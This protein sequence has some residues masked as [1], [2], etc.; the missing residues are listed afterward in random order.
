MKKYADWMLL[1][2]L[3]FIS[4]LWIAGCKKEQPNSTQ[5]KTKTPAKAENNMG[6]GSHPVAAE[7]E[8]SDPAAS[9]SE[10]NGVHWLTNY[11]QAKAEAAKEGK[12]LLINFSGSDWCIF[13]IK[14]EKEV[15]SK[16]EFARDANKYFVFLLVDFPNDT[17]N[18]SD[19]VRIQNQQLAR[20][21]GFEGLFPT[22]Y[23]AA[24]D[25]RPYAMAQYQ[26]IGPK[27]YMEYLLQIRKYKDR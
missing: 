19:E 18:Q 5:N 11:E 8:N 9:Q 22:I 20:M 15:F 2:A 16:E 4:V 26:Q 23:L 7:A 14:L 10:E 1:S 24:A 25:G 13:C 27:A 17:S 21:Y 12:D 3:I 6:D